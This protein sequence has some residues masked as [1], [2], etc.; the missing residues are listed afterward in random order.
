MGI[1]TTVSGKTV[2]D[3]HRHFRKNDKF[4]HP[5]PHVRM[6]KKPIPALF[7]LFPQLEARVREFIMKHLDCFAVEMLRGEL[8]NVMIPKLMEE[9]NVDG[10]SESLGHK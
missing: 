6:G 7:E 8:I 4:P 1:I 9:I 10:D 3:W 5:N 2:G